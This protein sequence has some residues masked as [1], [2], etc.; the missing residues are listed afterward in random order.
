ME[1]IDNLYNSLVRYFKFLEYTGTYD[2]RETNNLVIYL[3]IVN[4]IFEGNLSIHLDDE[5][6]LKLKHVLK[7]L[8]NGCIIDTVRDSI[9][10][11]DIRRSSDGIRFRHSEESDIRFM[12]NKNIRTTE[13]GA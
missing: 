2:R 3:F 12:E 6:L 13:P 10:L 11:E 9:K 1:H 5:G 7:C 4:E 8:Y